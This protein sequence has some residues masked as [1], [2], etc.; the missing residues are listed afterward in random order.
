M[1]SATLLPALLFLAVPAGAQENLFADRPVPPAR[2]QMQPVEGGIA[3]LDTETGAITLCRPQAGIMVCARGEDGA[4]AAVP[5]GDVT[6]D[7]SA[8][9]A[10]DTASPPQGD[11]ARPGNPA[12]SGPSLPGLERRLTQLE[13]RV[14]G[15]EK[16]LQATGASTSDEEDFQKSLGQARQVFQMFRDIVREMDED[17]RDPAEPTPNRT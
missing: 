12:G 2:Y 8:P 5:P 1:R 17:R 14:A 6:A 13:A 16:R 7:P 10:E 11:R 15:L 3:R 4:S 9:E